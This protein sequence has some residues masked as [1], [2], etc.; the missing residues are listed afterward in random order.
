MI[1]LLL[2]MAGG[3]TLLN[4]E[5][6]AFL[7]LAR[8]RAE[9]V[10]LGGD[11]RLQAMA[12]AIADHPRLRKADVA[13]VNY[14]QAVIPTCLQ[15]DGHRLSLFS[16]IAQFGSVQEVVA[17]EIRVELMFPANDAT[18]DYFRNAARKASSAE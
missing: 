4:W 7:A 15:F 6:T 14:N 2:A 3:S 18:A 10:H 8:L 5:E 16:T 9:I 12:D 11:A 13:S 17:S 1:E